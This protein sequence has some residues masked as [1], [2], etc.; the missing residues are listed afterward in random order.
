MVDWI[1]IFNSVSTIGDQDIDICASITLHMIA[2][3]FLMHKNLV[4]E[5]RTVTYLVFKHLNSKHK[6]ISLYNVITLFADKN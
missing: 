4:F 6:C 2:I 3:L 1:K 5:K